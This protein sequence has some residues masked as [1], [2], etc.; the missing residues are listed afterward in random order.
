MGK[1]FFLFLIIF[2][3]TSLYAE[4]TMT[5][6][7]ALSVQASDGAEEGQEGNLESFSA[8]TR[9]SSV[10]ALNAIQNAAGKMGMN[11]IAVIFTIIYNSIGT[12]FLVF[13]NKRK[14]APM[15]T[16]SGLL[17]V[18][19]YIVREG[20][21]VFMLGLALCGVLYLVRR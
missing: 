20:Y 15:M 6:A 5:D 21:S 11:T 4:D 13:G 14:N 7:A 8:N 3:V 10:N 19:P 18:F 12:A 9:A 2:S 1:A 17:I 16:V